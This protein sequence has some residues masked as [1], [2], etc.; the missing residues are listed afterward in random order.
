MKHLDYG[1]E[2]NFAELHCVP[3]FQSNAQVTNCDA[4]SDSGK[5]FPGSRNALHSVQK[6]LQMVMDDGEL[7][8]RT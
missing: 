5:V 8:E 6:Y 1:D 3:V 4:C 2:G 7:Q